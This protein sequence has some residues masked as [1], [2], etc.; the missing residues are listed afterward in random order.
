MSLQSVINILK[1]T[2]GTFTG[3]KSQ[4]TERK[5][6]ARLPLKK[7]AMHEIENRIGKILNPVVWRWFGFE[8]ERRGRRIPVASWDIES[9]ES[10][11]CCHRG[12]GRNPW[13]KAVFGCGERKSE[14]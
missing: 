1:R 6:E 14:Q 5:S 4:D 2:R 11:E 12:T 9:Q 8:E 7:I 3:Q 13:H 10:R